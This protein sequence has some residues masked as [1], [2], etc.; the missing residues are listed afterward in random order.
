MIKIGRRGS[1]TGTDRRRGQAGARGLSA[2]RRQPDPGH[3]A[4]A[5]RRSCGEPLDAGNGAFRRLEPRGDHHR[6]RQSGRQRDPGRGAGDV[7]HPLQRSLDAR[8]PARR[9]ST[10]ACG[11]PPATTVRYTLTFEPTNAV[12]FLT[13]PNAFVGFVADAIEAETGRSRSSPR[14]AAPRTRASL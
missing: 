3:D 8:E 12:A 13:P 10:A 6:R 7:Q 9:R 4:P 5:R 1:L 14:P 11:R 2:S